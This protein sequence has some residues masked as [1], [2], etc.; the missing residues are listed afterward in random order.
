MPRYI[1]GKLEAKLQELEEQGYLKYYGMSGSNYP[2]PLEEKYT[3]SI[4]IEFAGGAT[5]S[6]RACILVNNEN[7][8][9]AYLTL[10]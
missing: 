4:T 6:I 3:N 1:S 9:S 8:V 2:E 7:E 10:G 5:L